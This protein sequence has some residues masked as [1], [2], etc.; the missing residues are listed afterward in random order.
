MGQQHPGEH[1]HQHDAERGQRVGHVPRAG[2]GLGHRATGCVSDGEAASGSTRLGCGSFAHGAITSATRSAPSVP[3]TTASTRSPTPCRP[4]AQQL[5][6]A[7]HL[8]SL[9][10][11]PAGD[12]VGATSSTR[13]SNRLADPVLGSLADQLLGQ[14]GRRRPAGAS[15]SSVGQLAVQSAGWPR[16]RPR[17]SSRTRRSRPARRRRGSRAAGR[18]RPRSRRGTRTMTL[19]RIPACGAAARIGSIRSQEGVRIRRSGASGA[20]RWARRAGRTG[21]SSGTTFVGAGHRL[22]QARA[23][24]RP[25]AGR[26]PGSTR[27]RRPAESS[28]SSSLQSARSR[29]GPCRTRWS[30]R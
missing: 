1:R 14:V 15:I 11:R 23:A 30:S 9:V 29:R 21:R 19:L 24:S 4:V 8:G 12:L 2:L 7:V 13:T 6:G 25:A 18:R 3:T 26:T 22:D 28:A 16:C 17:R 20:A 5:Y 10:G 27:C